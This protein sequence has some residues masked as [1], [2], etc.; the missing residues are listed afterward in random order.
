MP[1]IWSMFLQAKY[2]LYPEVEDDVEWWGTRKKKNQA[3]KN[4]S[5]GAELLFFRS[6]SKNNSFLQI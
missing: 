2:D 5:L 6:K 4:Y 1:R 3:H